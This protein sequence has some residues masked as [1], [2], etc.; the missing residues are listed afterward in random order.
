MSWRAVFFINVP[1]ATIVLGL[2]YWRVPE[3][4]DNKG[5]KQ[6]DWSGAAFAT[7]GLGAVVYGLIESSR[8]GFGHPLVLV[9][10]AAGAVLLASFILVERRAPNPMLP[11][12]LFRSRNFSGANVLTLFLYTAL[13]GAMFFLPLNLIQVQGYSATQ[14]GAALLPFI[15]ILFVLSR[16]SGGLVKRYGSKAPLV[17]GPI[18]AALGYA[19]FIAPGVGGSYWTTFFPAVAVLGLGMAFSVAPL[20]TTVM[21]AVESNRAGVA[22]G[23]NNAVSRTAGLFGIA[24]LGIVILHAYSSELD[25]RLAPL[26]INAG[27]RGTI[28]QQRARL[29]ASEVPAGVSDETRVELNKAIHESFVFGFR[30]V[31]MTAVVLALA[32]AISAFM[33]IEGKAPAGGAPA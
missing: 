1:L 19:L 24:I 17:A 33:M 26:P 5:G 2:S 30:M 21:N 11:L 8:L 15:L 9:A 6:L 31:M 32:S 3:S 23:V 28:V 12:T 27:V 4:L 18:V 13:S 20:T 25:R 10:L 14:A 7:S 22:S 16:W 29:G